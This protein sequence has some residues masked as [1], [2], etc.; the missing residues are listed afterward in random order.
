[1][2]LTLVSDCSYP[3]SA[4]SS[5]ERPADVRVRQQQTHTIEQPSL[6]RHPDSRQAAGRYFEQRMT[7]ETAGKSRISAH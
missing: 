4:I 1:M 7:R 3:G 5:K 2:W 6:A